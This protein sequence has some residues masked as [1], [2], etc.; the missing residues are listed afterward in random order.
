MIA[1]TQG[2]TADFAAGPEYGR[3]TLDSIR[4]AIASPQVG[5]TPRPKIGL[6]GYSGGAIA[7]NWAAALAPAT[8][9]RSTDGSSGPPRA[10]CLVAPA[11]NLDYIEGSQIWAGVLA[12]ALVGAARGFEVDLERY[13]NPYGKKVFAEM[14]KASIAE[15][16]GA[17][18]GLTWKQMAK[19][20]FPDPEEIPCLR[21]HRQPAQPRSRAGPDGADVHRSGR[22][23][24]ARG[25]VGLT[26]GA[27]GRATAS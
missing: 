2:R 11:H 21:P 15:V 16:L 19:K 22:Q 6:F 10:A 5:L 23:R 9:P 14:R 4:A 26:P 20:R 12:M 7:T 24:R 13:L 27:S 18:P 17:Y 25:H 8:P 1:D 3:A